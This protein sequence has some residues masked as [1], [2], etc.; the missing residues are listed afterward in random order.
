MRM[1][2]DG[3]GI[4]IRVASSPSQTGETLTLRLLDSR[5]IQLETKH[6]GMSKTAREVFEKAIREPHGLILVTG[7]TGSGKTTTL[8]VALRTIATGDKHII[9]IEDPIEF[10]IQGINQ[11]QVNPPAGLTF[12][13]SLR[14]VLRQDPDVIMVGEIRDRE[15]AEISVNAAQT[16]HLVFS[17]LH[18]ID[19]SSTVTRLF[20]LGVNP[21]QFAHAL[22]LV[23]AQRLIR[24]VCPEC[25][26]KERPS[27]ETLDLIGIGEMDEATYPFLKGKKCDFCN[28]TGFHGRTGIYEILAPNS[29]I[30]TVLERGNV[31]T[32]ELRELA[33][34]AGMRTLREEAL[35]LLKQGMTTA[36]EVLR[37]TK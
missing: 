12:A 27:R 23:A 19:A 11:I 6:L 29:Q 14:S 1:E 4:D 20:D 33:I 30:R 10:R 37:V 35:L 8:Y 22:T 16:G 31:S 2:V 3:S 18:T 28:Q 15:T 9:S 24:L 7:P 34:S 13:T 25:K 5:T 21:N 26:H 36:D 32:A 17:T